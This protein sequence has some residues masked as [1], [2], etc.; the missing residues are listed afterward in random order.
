MIVS[1]VSAPRSGWIASRRQIRRRRASTEE[2]Q[3]PAAQGQE[4]SAAPLPRPRSRSGAPRPT[5]RRAGSCASPPPAP[6]ASGSRWRAR[7]RRDGPGSAC[8]SICRGRSCARV[9]PR[10]ASARRPSTRFA[11]DSMLSSG[12]RSPR[13]PRIRDRY[14]P[15]VTVVMSG[16]QPTERQGP[17]VNEKSLGPDRAAGRRPPMTLTAPRNRAYTPAEWRPGRTSRSSSPSSTRRPTWPSSTAA[18][19]Q[20]GAAWAA[21][22]RSSRRRRLHGRHAEAAARDRGRGPPRPRAAPPPELRP[23]GGVLGRVRP[24][25][26][27]DRGHQRRRPAERSRRHPAPRGPPGGGRFDLVCGWRKERQDPLSKKVPSWFANRLISWATGVHLHDYGCSLKAIRA[28]VVRSLRLYGEM[29]RFIPAVAS[30]MGV[31]VAEMPVNHRPRTRGQQ[32]IRPRAAPSACC[33]TSS[34]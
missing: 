31:S 9:R 23:D 24:R 28:E 19:G 10:R 27:R 25:A 34:P 22:T 15:S 33:S 13:S 8:P 20:P 14:D 30:W 18:D 26:G 29:H 11:V 1:S 17:A 3:V 2:G 16:S 21:P 12:W 32:Q 7:R 6:G 5:R 4:R